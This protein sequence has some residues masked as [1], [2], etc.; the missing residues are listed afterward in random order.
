VASVWLLRGEPGAPTAADCDGT[1]TMPFCSTALPGFSPAAGLVYGYLL[2][3]RWQWSG[4]SLAE[5]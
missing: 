4:S 1:A 3:Q 5:K 2:C